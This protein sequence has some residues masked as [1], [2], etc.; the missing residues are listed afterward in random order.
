MLEPVFVAGST[1]S[2]ATLHNA[3]D[4]ARKDIREGDTVIIEKAGDVIPRVVGAGASACGRRIRCR[5][6]M[7][8]HVPAVP[9]PPAR[10]RKTKRCGAART[11]R[12][13]RSCQRGLE[14]FASRGAMNIEGLGE[15]LIAAAAS[16]TALVKNYADVYHPDARQPRHCDG[17]LHAAGRQGD[18]PAIWREERRQGHRADRPQPA[19][20][21]A[22]VLYGLGIRHVGERGRRCWR[23]V[24]VGRRHCAGAGRQLEQTHEIGPVLAESVRPGSTSP[25]T[26]S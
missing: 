9:D 14:H 20:G 2:M 21:P 23:S 12:A 10:G 17:H 26:S 25:P 16:T 13:R 11:P 18:R 4:I 1:I 6:Q 3:D 7:P 22:R 8:G 15:S 24:R 5:G 19:G